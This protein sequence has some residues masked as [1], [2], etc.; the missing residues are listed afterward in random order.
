[1]VHGTGRAVTQR[2]RNRTRWL[3]ALGGALAAATLGWGPPGRAVPAAAASEKID[4]NFQVRPLLSDRC[5][6]C[7]GPDER[8]RMAK[9]RL[10]RPDESRRTARSGQPVVLPGDPDRSEVVR[11]IT[12]T[13]PAVRM[14]PP[15][16]NRVLAPSEVE[17]LRTWIAQGAEYRPHWA[18]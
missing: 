15:W 13:D 6:P 8:S 17:L 18:F 3:R 12:S 11:R 9:L 16:S 7:H 1:R 14:P 4:F 10:D 5:F 2:S